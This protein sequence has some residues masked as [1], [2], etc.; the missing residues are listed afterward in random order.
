MRLAVLALCLCLPLPGLAQDRAREIAVTGTGVV[1][2]VPDMAEIRVEV[3][4]QARKAEGAMAA[5]SDA[6]A[7]VLAGAEAAGIEARDMRT[8]AIGLGPLYDYPPDAPPR[9][10]GYQATSSLVLRIRDLA[11]VGPVLDRLVGDGANG[12]AG[13]DF[14]VADPDPLRDEARRAAVADARDQAALLARAAGVTL[15]PVMRITDGPAAVP[16]PVFDQPMMLEAAGRAMPVAPGEIE[17]RES[18]SVIYA[19]AGDG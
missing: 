15:G 12:I 1:A 3:A 18:V 16:G 2:A 4:R 8:A 11:R 10:T 6:V 17:F 19:I 9:F 7:A 14:T 13:P 5:A